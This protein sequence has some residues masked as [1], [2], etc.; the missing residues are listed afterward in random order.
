MLTKLKLVLLKGKKREEAPGAIGRASQ[1]REPEP[2]K[3]ISLGCLDG[4]AAA[5]LRS[6]LDCLP[7][8][9]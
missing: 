3:L 8:V 9:C 7:I 5:R 2:P 4:S 1:G 6:A